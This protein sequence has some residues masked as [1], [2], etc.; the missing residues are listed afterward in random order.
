MHALGRQSWTTSLG[1]LA[2]SAVAGAA[3]VLP[4][5]ALEWRLGGGFP[6]GVPLALFLALWLLAIGFLLAAWSLARDV[7]S[8][9]GTRLLVRR[10]TTA[11]VAL[12][13]AAL[14]IILVRDQM[15][16]FLGVPNC[17]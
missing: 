10:W 11:A 15:P 13:L 6:E 2:T 14:W 17:D 7:R 1:R 12:V 4:F 5:A 16:C 3:L 9:G 8:D